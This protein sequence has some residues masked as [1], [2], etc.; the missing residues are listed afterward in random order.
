MG[1]SA[2]P[3]QRQKALDAFDPIRRRGMRQVTVV[4]TALVAL[5]RLRRMHLRLA[6]AGS[7]RGVRSRLGVARRAAVRAVV[8]VVVLPGLDHRVVVVLGLHD[9][10]RDLVSLS[11][12]GEGAGLRFVAGLEVGGHCGN[13]DCEECEGR[14]DT[15]EL[16]HLLLLGCVFSV[17]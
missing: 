12:A 8:G 10:G 6:R 13:A 5:G 15:K 11:A 14:E 16:C 2:G 9:V 17:I 7:R 3:R 1:Y 4:L